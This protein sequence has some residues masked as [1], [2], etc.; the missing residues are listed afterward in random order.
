MTTELRARLQDASGRLTDRVLAEMYV[1]PFWHDRFGER[2]DKHG[3]QDGK[4]HI[5]YLCEALATGDAGVMTR[6]AVW[7]QQVLTTRGMCTRHLVDNFARLAR[8]IEDESWPDAAQALDL[9]QRAIAALR[10]GNAA[11]HAVQ[12]FA[13]EAAQLAAERLEIDRELVEHELAYLAD[14]AADAIALGM[15]A[16]VARR[17][18]WAATY[19]ERHGRTLPEATMLG[20][21]RDVLLERLPAHREAIE[22]VLP[23]RSA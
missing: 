16:I 17:A 11:A 13:N 5:D 10:H 22:Q 18:S 12:A 23:A 1:D 21:L 20:V 4:F 6:Y 7:L 9:L 2:A 19:H 3:R 15:P 14:Y 8:A